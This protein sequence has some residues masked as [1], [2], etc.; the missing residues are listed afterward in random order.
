MCSFIYAMKNM[1]TFPFSVPHSFPATFLVV[2]G[3]TQR[4]VQN[5]LSRTDSW[6]QMVFAIERSHCIYSIHCYL[7]FLTEFSDNDMCVSYS[8]LLA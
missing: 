6:A 5:S 3:P 7:C 4:C 2:W 1:K 8:N